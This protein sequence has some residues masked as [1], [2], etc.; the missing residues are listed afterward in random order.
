MGGALRFAGC[1]SFAYA[2][3]FVNRRFI[4]IWN[5][6]LNIRR[7]LAYGA[8]SVSIA[9]AEAMR[10]WNCSEAMGLCIR[11]FLAPLTLREGIFIL[12]PP[13]GGAFGCNGK[14]PDGGELRMP[15]NQPR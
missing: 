9:L 11:P 10:T 3:V 5:A 2:F 7:V 4:A 15:S 14:V 1:I 12:S 13:S 8:V 6:Q